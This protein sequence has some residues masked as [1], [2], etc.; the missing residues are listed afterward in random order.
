ML[1]SNIGQNST[2]RPELNVLPDG[3]KPVHILPG[4]TETYLGAADFSVTAPAAETPLTAPVGLDVGPFITSLC[5]MLGS[6][7]SCNASR[8]FAAASLEVRC[9]TG[10]SSSTTTAS[11][12]A[13]SLPR[14]R[15]ARY[16]AQTGCRGRIDPTSLLWGR[17]GRRYLALREPGCRTR[18]G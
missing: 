7:L 1:Q 8:H 4:S 16:R 6:L 14:L 12:D 11:P 5:V 18:R 15:P 10:R 3:K 9:Q 17:G 13:L 2:D